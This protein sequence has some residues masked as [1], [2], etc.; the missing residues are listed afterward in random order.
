MK[1]ETAGDP[2]S[3][4]KWTRRTTARIAAE[5]Q[6]LGIQVSARTVRAV[7]GDSSWA[8]WS[9]YWDEAVK[10]LLNTCWAGTVAR[11][12]KARRSAETAKPSKSVFTPAADD[13]P[14][15]T[16]RICSKISGA[17]WSR[18]D[19]PIRPSAAPASIHL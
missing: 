13:E 9:T 7:S 11:F 5:L 1:H 8:G 4:L 17:L 12:V 10:A 19:K 6:F 2:M 16:Y 14:K 18:R 3:G 15:R